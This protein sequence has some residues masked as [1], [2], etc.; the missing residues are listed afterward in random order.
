MSDKKKEK[1]K[2]EAE[3]LNKKILKQN[4]KILED[5]AKEKA[6]RHVKEQNELVFDGFLD[7]FEK[8]YGKEVAAKSSIE[9]LKMI[10]DEL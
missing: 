10:N 8:K 1:E 9:I 3:K 6:K 7:N 2:A 4:Q 5:K